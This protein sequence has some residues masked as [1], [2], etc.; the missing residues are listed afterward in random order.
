[1]G[2]TSLNIP[3]E[4]PGLASIPAWFE[5]PDE[6]AEVAVLM[7]HGSNFG[8]D[9]PWT[10]SLV[11]GLVSR[12]IAVLSFDYAY[13]ARADRRHSQVID[14]GAMETEEMDTDQMDT[15]AVL[16][17]VH[18]LALGELHRLAPTARI[19]LAG[20]SL[21]ARLST[22]L[23]AKGERCHGLLLFGY[24]LH[25]KHKR[26]IYSEHFATLV[27]PTL[28]LQGTRDPLC[29]LKLLRRELPRHGGNTTLEVIAGADHGFRRPDEEPDEVPSVLDELA[30]R[31]VNWALATWP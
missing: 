26:R 29:D 30:E 4:L 2:R 7:A 25:E 10:R 31:A 23:A 13:R 5:E 22:I 16:E 21:G 9:S 24:P 1:M 3:V 8:K 12:G 19:V 15:V 17:L 18:S 11:S 28:F 6:A 20:K 27:Q 14:S